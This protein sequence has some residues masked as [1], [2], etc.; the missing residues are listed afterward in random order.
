M[1]YAHILQLAE[2]LGK[3][4]EKENPKSVIKA[5]KKITNAEL[6]PGELSKETV[7]DWAMSTKGWF[8]VRDCYSELQ[9]AT[10]SQKSHIRTVFTRLEQSGLLEHSGK[11]RGEYRKVDQDCPV[12]EW[13]GAPTEEVPIRLPFDLHNHVIIYPGD[14]IIVA[15]EKNSGKTAFWLQMVNMNLDNKELIKFYE[16]FDVG[17]LWNIYENELDGSGVRG[18]LEKAQFDQEEWRSKVE[19]RERMDTFSQV[20]KPEYVNIIDYIQVLDNF[21]EVGKKIEDV[22]RAIHGN[23]GI[24]VIM[25]QK[26]KGKDIA[27]GGATS[28]DRCKLYLSFEFKKMKVVMCKTPRHLDN[29]RGWTADFTLARGSEFRVTRSLGPEATDDQGRRY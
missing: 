1:N 6:I 26:D 14:I 28:L 29:P 7:E 2:E 9:A 21:Y 18:R 8:S 4:A 25:L 17:K 15:G 27:R 5:I 16:P 23:Q 19:I 13:W 10:K 3:S 11:R 20:L 24:G 22:Y 12:V